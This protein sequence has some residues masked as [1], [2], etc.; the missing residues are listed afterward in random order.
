MGTDKKKLLEK[1]PV[2]FNDFLQPAATVETVTKL[3]EVINDLL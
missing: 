3:W 2:F 1:L